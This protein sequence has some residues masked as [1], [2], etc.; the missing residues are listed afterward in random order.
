MSILKVRDF[1]SIINLVSENKRKGLK[2]GLICGCFD[3]LHIGHVRLFKFAKS[4]VDILTL[5]LDSDA[6]IRKSK[7]ENRPIHS[8]DMRM[9]L[10]SHLELVDYVFPLNYQ[11]EF[12]DDSSYIFW[13]DILGG[14]KPSAIITSTL[15]DKYANSKREIAQK[16]NIEFIPFKEQYDVSTTAIEKM[17]VNGFLNIKMNYKWKNIKNY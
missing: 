13:E 4:K 5:G 8:Q 15:A 17:Y 6:A 2:V 10:I 14:I 7:G 1:N 12:G 9:E 16:F 11:G 3:V